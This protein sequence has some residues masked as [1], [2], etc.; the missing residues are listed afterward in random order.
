VIQIAEW[1]LIP[2][3]ASRRSLGSSTATS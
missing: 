3:H 1:F 2:W